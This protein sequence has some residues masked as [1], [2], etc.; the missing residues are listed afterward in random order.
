M[1]ATIYNRTQA[2]HQVAVNVPHIALTL[3]VEIHTHH[4]RFAELLRKLNKF[5]PRGVMSQNI[6]HN[7]F[8]ICFFCSFNNSFSTYHC[9]GERFFDEHMT[10]RFKCQN[11]KGFMRIG[12]SRNTYCIRFCGDKSRF[13]V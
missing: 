2:F 3:L 10:T 8:F 9:V 7:N 5:F 13:V 12:V 6:T 1:H 4:K 11:R